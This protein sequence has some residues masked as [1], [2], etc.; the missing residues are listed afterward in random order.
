MVISRERI[1]PDAEKVVRRLLEHG[2]EAYLVGGC[3]RDLLLGRSPKDFDVSTSATPNEIRA[4]FRNCRLIGRRF[5]LAHVFFGRKIIETSTF[6]APPR[7]GD[8]DE[9]LIRRD[10]VFGTAEEDARRRDFTINGLFFD[11]EAGEVIDHVGGTPDLESRLVRTIGDP[12][13][14]FREDPVRILRAIKFAARLGLTIEAATYDAI[15]QTRDEIPKC[16]SARV[17]EEIYR[18]L[19]GGAARTSFDLFFETG[20]GHVLSPELAWLFGVTPADEVLSEEPAFPGLDRCPFSEPPLTDEQLAGARTRAWGLLGQLD[21]I[22]QGLTNYGF[23]RSPALE[24]S[25]ALVLATALFPF[26]EPALADDDADPHFVIENVM[27]P[28]CARLSVSRKDTERC[29]QIL[30]SQARLDPGRKRRGKPSA[31]VRRETFPDALVLF[32]LSASMDDASIA[33]EI[34]RWRTLWRKEQNGS[35]RRSGLHAASEILGRELDDDAPDRTPGDDDLPRRRRKRRGGRGRR[36]SG[37][38]RPG[39]S[40][41]AAASGDGAD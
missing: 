9:L 2:F 29:R 33:E 7:E 25:N 36:R 5:R 27:R 3:V 38:A 22:A 20:V 15:L 17:I 23:N 31:L 16:P 40:P 1:D 4:V 10:N 8:Q 24:L 19:R 14:R 37:E 13:V 32:E 26:V 12:V 41:L 11:V 35:S 21:R 28:V 18:L 6:R 34:A 39:S 30:L